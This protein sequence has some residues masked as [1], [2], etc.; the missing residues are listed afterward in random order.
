[1]PYV[2]LTKTGREISKHGLLGHV[3][4]AAVSMKDYDVKATHRGV[5]REL[6][7]SE[8]RTLIRMMSD[9]SAA[10]RRKSR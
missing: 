3:A 8:F 10:K 7:V 2:I 4:R 5:I 9:I 1:M 6:T